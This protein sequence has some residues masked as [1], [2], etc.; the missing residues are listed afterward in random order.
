MALATLIQRP[1]QLYATLGLLVSGGSLC[2][3]YTGHALFLPYWFVKRRGLAMGI[4]FAGVGAGSIVLLPVDA[5]ASSS[6]RAGAR[7]RSPWRWSCSSC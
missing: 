6:A 4:A 1:W 7:H 2:L 5:A 3:G